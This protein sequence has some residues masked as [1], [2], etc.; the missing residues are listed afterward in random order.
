MIARRWTNGLPETAD[1]YYD[2]EVKD[3]SKKLKEYPPE[4]LD[5]SDAWVTRSALEP[6]NFMAMKEKSRDSD[7][8]LTLRDRGKCIK[9]TSCTSD[10]C[11]M[12][13]TTGKFKAYSRR[14]RRRM[15]D[16]LH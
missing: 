6:G 3:V 11:A 12:Y 9:A 1:Y 13:K 15:A 8:T 4:N 10:V 14:A 2:L 7:I 16:R 5:L